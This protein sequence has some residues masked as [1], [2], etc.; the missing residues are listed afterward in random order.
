[1]AEFDVID[2]CFQHRSYPRRASS[3]FT[4]PVF[5]LDRA[6]RCILDHDVV[7]GMPG[8]P[9]TCQFKHTA[10]GSRYQSSVARL[11]ESEHVAAVKSGAPLLPVLTAFV[12]IK[13]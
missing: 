12:R 11:F 10:V 9:A 5:Q 7:D 2:A 3:R 8:G 4:L 13:N 1:G 6:G